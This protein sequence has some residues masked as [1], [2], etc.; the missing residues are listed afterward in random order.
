MGR[1]GPLPKKNGLKVQSGKLPLNKDALA[2][3][4]AP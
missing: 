1:R 4:L 2:E 3:I